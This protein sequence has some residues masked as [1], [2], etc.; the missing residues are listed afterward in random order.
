[1]RFK[2]SAVAGY[3]A[4][5]VTGVNSIS[6]AIDFTK[7]KTEGLLG[8]AVE[9]NDLTE[10]ERR[11]MT[12]FKV[13]KSL[14]PQPDIDVPLS[15]LEHPV[16][17]FVWDDFSAKPDHQYDYFF[18]PMTGKPGALV[19]APKPIKIKVKT[20]PLFSDKEHD[21]FFN[22]GA[23][24]GRAYGLKFG[25]LNPHALK[26]PK[27][28]EAMQWLSRNLDDAMYRFISQAKKGDRLLCCF[29]E[30]SYLPVIEALKKA[31]DDGVDVQLV[32]DMKKTSNSSESYPRDESRRK[33]KE[34]GIPAGRVTERTANPKDIMHNKF[35]VWLQGA[36]AKPAEVWTGSTNISFGGIHG[37]TNVGH[38][39]RNGKVAAK[40]AEY[41]QLLKD[42]PGG[43]EKDSKELQEQ[44]LVAL[45][46][47]VEK[48]QPQETPA[49][50]S[51]LPKGVTPQFSPMSNDVTTLKLYAEMLD[52]AKHFAC[53]TFPFGINQKMTE[54]FTDNIE[55]SPLVFMLFDEK[56]EPAEF[57]L[58]ELN[59]VYPVWGVDVD[60]ELAVLAKDSSLNVKLFLNRHAKYIH[61]KFLLMDP[62]SADPVVVTGSA[63]FSSKSIQ[64][65]DENMLLIRGDLRAADIYFTEFNR[66][67]NFFY[68]GMALQNMKAEEKKSGISLFLDPT[69]GWL[70]KYAPGSMRHKR[71]KAFAAMGGISK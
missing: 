45:Q 1:M 10:K 17:S 68:M 16:Q 49:G 4:F 27:K 8:F 63:N 20:E 25:K 28:S 3:K 40:F 14:V 67:F 50:L 59:N 7:A 5:A 46:K 57:P 19:K 60:D 18:Y 2:S 31:I 30:F 69:D 51:K 36:A 12:G 44:K 33:L 26:E 71:V 54:V 21:V 23:I 43:S 35:M 64:R 61:T 52:K 39:M 24:S 47:T 38:W 42:D 48:I 6:F 53:I 34:A 65:N 56:P 41:W 13:F 32:L 15:T 58:G 22:R 66:V 29:Y 62:L 55:S 9:R 70:K 11:F 37:H